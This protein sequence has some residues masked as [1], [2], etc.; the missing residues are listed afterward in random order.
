MKL[1]TVCK[2]VLFTAMIAGTVMTF[3]ACG[4]SSGGNDMENTFMTSKAAYLDAIAWY[5][6]EDIMLVTRE[7][8]VYELYYKKDIFGTTDPGMK[9]EKT[10]I[11]TGTYTSAPSADGDTTH[12]DLSLEAPTRIY[13]E[14]HGKAFGRDVYNVNCMF[15]TANWT[16]AMTTIAFPSGSEDGA[17]DFLSTYGK[18]MTVTVEDPSLYQEDTSL[19][20]RIVSMTEENLEIT[21]N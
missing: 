18:A 13:M 12:L 10:I 20:Y 1:K 11:Y 17:A 5:A 7:G 8:D 3:A 21:G 16:D 9:G 2:Q 6:N 4:G 14:Q 19:Y 15:D